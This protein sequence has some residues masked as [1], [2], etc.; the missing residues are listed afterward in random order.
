MEGDKLY[1][2]CYITSTNCY[3]ISVKTTLLV[4]RLA[5]SQLCFKEKVS[6]SLYHLHIYTIYHSIYILETVLSYKAQC[7]LSVEILT[8]GQ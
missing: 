5:S 2:S 8:C 1:V 4:T 7:H 6:Q 3:N